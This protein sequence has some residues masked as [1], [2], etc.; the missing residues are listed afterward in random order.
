MEF[1]RNML[2]IGTV[3]APASN[4]HPETVKIAVEASED[5]PLGYIVINKE[6]FDEDQ[7]E[8][9][10]GESLEARREYN[11]STM[12]NAKMKE[13]LDAKKVTYADNAN[14]GVLMTLCKEHLK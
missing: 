10:E 1:N 5:N 8:L 12:S 13:L 14:R 9:I 2:R 3:T 11:F 7:H 6:D 4:A